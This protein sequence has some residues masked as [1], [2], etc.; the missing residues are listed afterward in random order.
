MLNRL[1][2][3]EENAVFK[4]IGNLDD[5]GTDQARSNGCPLCVADQ[6]R[7]FN[8]SFSCIE[9]EGKFIGLSYRGEN[10]HPLDTIIIYS[11]SGPSK[12]GQ[13]IKITDV[14]AYQ[15]SSYRFT[16]R[17]FDRIQGILQLAPGDSVEEYGVRDIQLS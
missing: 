3:D 2:Y 15:N 17:L 5:I 6:K 7:F 10:Y 14:T 12:I 4:E 1:C 11:K 8:A 13:I 16:V 9:E